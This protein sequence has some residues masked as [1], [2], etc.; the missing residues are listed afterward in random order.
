MSRQSLMAGIQYRPDSQEG[1]LLPQASG[2]AGMAPAA[3]LQHVEVELTAS[4]AAE[5]QG[6]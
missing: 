2:W 3:H 1:V 5:Q 6:C 4:S